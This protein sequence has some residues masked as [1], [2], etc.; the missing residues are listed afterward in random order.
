[1][2]STN[3]MASPCVVP[4]APSPADSR[5]KVE[6]LVEYIPALP[7]DERIL[8]A[9]GLVPGREE[10]LPRTCRTI[11]D[12]VAHLH[13]TVE[14]DLAAGRSV[15]GLALVTYAQTSS[16]RRIAVEWISLVRLDIG[17]EDWRRNPMFAHYL[18][19]RDVRLALEVRPL[20]SRVVYLLVR[21]R[22]RRAERWFW[23]LVEEN[24]RRRMIADRA[25]RKSVV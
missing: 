8:I 20:P 24:K 1:M 16:S 6:H 14:E 10:I 5:K 13:A 12:G 15:R 23:D 4:R 18:A 2:S 21:P 22:Q 3:E 11:G 19:V 9:G 25:D 7:I 17:A